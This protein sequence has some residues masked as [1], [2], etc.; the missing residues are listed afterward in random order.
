[1]DISIMKEFT[2]LLEQ[3]SLEIKGVIERAKAETQSQ[4]NIEKSLEVMKK[5]MK[6]IKTAVE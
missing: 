1:M 6:E 5:E 2:A 4:V 3:F